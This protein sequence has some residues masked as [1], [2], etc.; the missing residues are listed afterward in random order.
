[1]PHLRIIFQLLMLAAFCCPSA[2]AEGTDLSQKPIPLNK[3]AQATLLNHFA[4]HPKSLNTLVESF[5]VPNI[6][7]QSKGL[8]VTLSKNGKTRACWGSINAQEGNL[9][10][11]TIVTCEE[12]LSKEYRYPPIK[13]SELDALKCQVTVV[14]K[15]EPVP[16]HATLNPLLDGLMVRSGAKAAVLLPGEASDPHY[17]VMQCKVKAGITPQEPCQIYRMRAHVFR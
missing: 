16:R 11:A 5:T 17:Q 7:K 2:I 6:Y 1:M 10:K 4:P 15:I 12:A 14:E 8:F 3:I 9:V 13:R